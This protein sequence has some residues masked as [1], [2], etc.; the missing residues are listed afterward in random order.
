M[1]TKNREK[2]LLIATGTWPPCY[3]LNLLVITPFD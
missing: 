2:L 1:E 3:L